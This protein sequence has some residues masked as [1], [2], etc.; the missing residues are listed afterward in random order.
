MPDLKDFINDKPEDERIRKWREE[1]HRVAEVEKAERIR[2]RDEA[3]AAEALE[4]A[5]LRK[6]EAARL[7]PTNEDITSAMIDLER[8]RTRDQFRTL[9]RFGMVCLVPVVATFVYLVTVAT[10]L[11]EARSVI[12][13]TSPAI[14]KQQCG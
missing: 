3:R 12:A 10:P 14:A 13:V 11:Y 4:Q 2:R 8:A 6:E 7:L 1:R 5:K 9:L